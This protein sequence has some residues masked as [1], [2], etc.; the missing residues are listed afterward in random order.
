MSRG[1]TLGWVGATLAVAF[2]VKALLALVFTRSSYVF[3]DPLPF[4]AVA[5]DGFFA[6]GDVQVPVRAFFVVAVGLALAAAATWTLDR[7]RF[8]RGLQAIAADVEGARVVGVPVRLL[9]AAAFGLAGG[10]AALAAI[11][12]APSVPFDTE[13]GVLLGLKGLV[14]ALLVRFAS[15]WRAF[16]AGVALGVAEAAIAGL[17]V[18]GHEL[19]SQYR[20]VLPL[21]I[22][23]LIVALRPA[24]EALEE[25]E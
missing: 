22:V 4:R 13:T 8:G 12:A 2:A 3:P 21:A 19:G 24:R 17:T 11:T 15:P 5:R 14:V 7:T 1:S 23:L 25:Q 20:E 10:L 16:T 9:V 6:V 18:F